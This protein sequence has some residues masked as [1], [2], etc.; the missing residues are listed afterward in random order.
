MDEQRSQQPG[1]R[2][3]GAD[4]VKV[5]RGKV[6]VTLRPAEVPRHPPG[7]AQKALDLVDER[8]KDSKPA[9]A[10]RRLQ[11]TLGTAQLDLTAVQAELAKLENE[12]RQ[13][14][15][16]GRD[17][18]NAEKRIGTLKARAA[19]LTG[20]I[21]ELREMLAEQQQLAARERYVAL[22]AVRRDLWRR[23]QAERQV[24]TDRLVQAVGGILDSF[25]ANK[26][27]SEGLAL[28]IDRMIS[29]VSGEVDVNDWTLIEPEQEQ[30]PPA[31]DEAEAER[32]DLAEIAG[33]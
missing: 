21:A 3:V 32:A 29:A 30:P 33:R 23:L 18:G 27:E 16:D 6:I 11:A 28:S 22:H 5:E 7:I 26:A 17:V 2:V 1:W 4:G 20:R 31:V 12:R 13:S 8:L 19:T 9:A 25:L 10:V 24:I 14:L 15:Y